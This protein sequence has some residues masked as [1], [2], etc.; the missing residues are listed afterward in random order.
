MR[1]LKVS[2]NEVYWR[3]L[4]QHLPYLEQMVE[5]TPLND[6]DIFE[7]EQFIQALRQHALGIGD[8]RSGSRI[9]RLLAAIAWF[10]GCDTNV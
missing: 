10:N 7:K 3:G 2:F 6:W 5:K 4:G 1:R 8:V 9:G